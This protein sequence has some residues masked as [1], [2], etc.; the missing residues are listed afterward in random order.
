MDMYDGKR[1]VDADEQYAAGVC[2]I[3]RRLPCDQRTLI[4]LV[5]S[6]KAMGIYRPLSTLQTT[7]SKPTTGIIEDSVAAERGVP[8]TSGYLSNRE[9][10]LLPNPLSSHGALIT[11][12]GVK[13]AS[14]DLVH[15]RDP[16][17]LLRLELTSP[18]A[19]SFG[20]VGTPTHMLVGRQIS[21]YGIAR[22]RVEMYIC[23]EMIGMNAFVYILC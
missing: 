11:P 7:D 22:R 20:S 13:Q 5:T 23:V 18:T 15:V 12:D 6:V 9:K 21:L 4:A 2:R 1:W 17:Y 3:E 10:R 14:C 8:N 16:L 19:L